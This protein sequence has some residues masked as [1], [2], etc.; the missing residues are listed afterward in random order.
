MNRQ[1]F[2]AYAIACAVLFACSSTDDKPA[3][4]NSA[5]SCDLLATRCHDSQT[6]LG[7]ECHELG[8]AGD[9]SACGPRK[10][11]CLA[12]CPEGLGEDEPKADSGT[13]AGSDAGGDAGPTA[14]EA[15]CSCMLA[16]C[17]SE[18]GYPFD[19]EADCLSDCEDFSE[20]ELDCYATS[21]ESAKEQEDKAHECEHANGTTACH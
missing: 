3:A 20:E 11:E 5:G 8:H 17:A 10:D 21:C 1:S 12:E 13:D 6:D 7:V 14:C 2:Y 15:Y 9:D 19:D 18:P 4:S 16:T